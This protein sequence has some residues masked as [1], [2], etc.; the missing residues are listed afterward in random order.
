ML[1]K[2]LSKEVMVYNI[3]FH[4]WLHGQYILFFLN[5][6]CSSKSISHIEHESLIIINAWHVTSNVIKWTGN[7]SEKCYICSRTWSTG[8]CIQK[9][10][11]LH[12]ED[13]GEIPDCSS[14]RYA[15]SSSV[16]QLRIKVSH[17]AKRRCFSR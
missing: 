7:Y 12:Q 11:L 5:S 17:I 4:V 9:T 3:L 15:G 6:N 16:I 14:P 10:Y 8:L 1:I 13:G 2:Y